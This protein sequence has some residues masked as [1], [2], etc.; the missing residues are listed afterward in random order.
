[1]SQEN[2]AGRLSAQEVKLDRSAISRIESEDRYLMDYE[3]VALAA[4]LKTCGT[5]ALGEGVSRMVLGIRSRE[6]SHP[7]WL[8]ACRADEHSSYSL[9]PADQS[10][11]PLC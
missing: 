3:E 10:S 9:L 11:S 6:P 8:L 5:A 1:M 4:A 7:G 2:L